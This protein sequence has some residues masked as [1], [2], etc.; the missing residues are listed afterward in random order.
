M[1]TETINREALALP[2]QERAEL[3]E[4]LLS[5]LDSL[6]ETEV[7]QLWVKEAVR[8]A[9]EI[10]SGVT[11]LIPAQLVRVEAQALLK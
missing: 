9:A 2:V 1:N 7:E 6:S 3:A 11:R 10:D 5:S 4:R 8:R